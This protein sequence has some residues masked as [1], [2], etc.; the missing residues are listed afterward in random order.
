[1]D[2]VES[3]TTIGLLIERASSLLFI[4]GLTW[5]DVSRSHTT[6]RQVYNIRIYILKLY[7]IS[8]PYPIVREFH[9]P[10]RKKGGNVPKR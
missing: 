2:S 5:V 4:R 6:P 1:M 7:E 9:F 8:I 3:K 10:A